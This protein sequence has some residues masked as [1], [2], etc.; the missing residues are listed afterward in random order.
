M[1]QVET[2]IPRPA[3]DPGRYLSHPDAPYEVVDGQVVELPPMGFYAATVASLIIAELVNFL[4]RHPMGRLTTEGAYILD[5]VRDVRRR[6]DAAFLSFERWPRDRPT[7]H[8]GDAPVAPDLAIEVVSPSDTHADLR[9]K[10]REYF[11]AG[12]RMVWVI[13]PIERQIA[14]YTTPKQVR[15]L[16]EDEELDGGDVLPGFHMP[17]GPLFA[18][19]AC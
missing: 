17:V 15:I 19:P 12:V 13:D 9:R 7:P 10:L 16:D 2:P 14:V 6:P 4:R 18:D 11:A 1:S 3:D 8:K 5:P